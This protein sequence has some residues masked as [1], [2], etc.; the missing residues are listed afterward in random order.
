MRAACEVREDVCHMPG[1]QVLTWQIASHT[2]VSQLYYLLLALLL[3]HPVKNVQNNS[4][5]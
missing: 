4:K 2:H 1:F 3:G 5:V